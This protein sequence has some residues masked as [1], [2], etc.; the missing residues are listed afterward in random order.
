MPDNINQEKEL[1]ELL[2]FQPVQKPKPVSCCTRLYKNTQFLFTLT[3]VL[4]TT[5]F[6]A[7]SCPEEIKKETGLDIPG[8]RT[9]VNLFAAS[10]II[11]Y[12]FT[13]WDTIFA[14]KQDVV[15]TSPYIQALIQPKENDN[16]EQN[17]VDTSAYT[18]GLLLPNTNNDTKHLINKA[19]YDAL[20]E[21]FGQTITEKK[22]EP[23]DE[24]DSS[25]S[26][27]EFQPQPNRALT[28]FVKTCG[29]LDAFIPMIT[30]DLYTQRAFE[31]ITQTE[32]DTQATGYI[33]LLAL[34]YAIRFLASY[35]Y[36]RYRIPT[37]VNTYSQLFYLMKYGLPKED[38]LS[39]W[40]PKSKRLQFLLEYTRCVLTA[41]VDFTFSFFGIRKSIVHLTKDPVPAT[42]AAGVTGGLYSMTS[43]GN[44]GNN[45][46]KMV[47]E[48]NK[49]ERNIKFIQPGY[50]FNKNKIK[51]T[52][53]AVILAIFLSGTY[54]MCATTSSYTIKNLIS[55]DWTFDRDD[56]LRSNSTYR[57]IVS[58]ILPILVLKK[59]IAFSVPRF[60]KSFVKRFHNL[61]ETLYTCKEMC[62]IRLKQPSIN[63][64]Y[65]DL[66]QNTSSESELTGINN[67]A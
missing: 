63:S 47:F 53:A 50:P 60:L 15:D 19:V 26:S 61:E 20:L 24:E 16:K 4:I 56:I 32:P 35:T 3:E 45:V 1:N 55:T 25:F 22:F 14:P 7:S 51:Y 48:D 66:E 34:S 43:L 11:F 42:I 30:I 12:V 39:C 31:F 27:L 59:I 21:Q 33:A 52:A 5:I 64:N 29:F 41:A 23:L 10:K 58:L 49:D 17:R 57:G 36:F 37:N 44:N 62:E 6:M 8:V 46:F 18:Q 40:N 67:N 54:V 38:T 28:Y 9:W 65:T 2:F 13:R